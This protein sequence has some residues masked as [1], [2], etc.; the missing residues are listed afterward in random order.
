MTLQELINRLQDM[1]SELGPNDDPDVRFAQQ[2]NWPFEY[3]ISDLILVQQPEL[4]TRDQFDALS[5]EEQEAAEERADSGE[6][7]YL[8]D[9]Q[10]APTAVIYL[11]EGAQ[12]GYLPGNVSR[13]L[14]WR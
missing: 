4:M 6:L 14:G 12:L 10:E 7:V 11:A 5:E 1:Q 2:P 3:S 8:E 9:N 13:E